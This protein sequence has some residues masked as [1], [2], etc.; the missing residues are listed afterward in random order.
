MVVEATVEGDVTRYTGIYLC[1]KVEGLVGPVR[2]GR[3]Y[4]VDLWQDLHVLPIIFGAGHD[5]IAA[6]PALWHAVRQRHQR[7]LALLHPVVR[8]AW[9]RTT[10]T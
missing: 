7:R 10:S 9:L 1:R 2:S 4:S 6:I 8:H 5:G 3:Y